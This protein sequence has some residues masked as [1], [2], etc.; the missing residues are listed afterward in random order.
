MPSLLT[1]KQKRFLR[2]LGHELKPVVQVGWRGATDALVAKVGDELDAHELIK[3]KVGE[4]SEDDARAVAARL[5][6]ALGARTVQVIGRTILTYRARADEP[7]IRL[8]R[9]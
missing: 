4:N 2:Q 9:L 6:Q 1:N 5:E 7:D 8:P 3:I